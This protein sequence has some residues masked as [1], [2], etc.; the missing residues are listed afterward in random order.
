M[1]SLMDNERM[2]ESLKVHP[3]TH[4]VLLATWIIDKLLNSEYV[5][6]CVVTISDDQLINLLAEGS[7]TT[8]ATMRILTLNK[9]DVT[10]ISYRKPDGRI[11]GH[12]YIINLLQRCDKP[13]H[14]SIL[15]SKAKLA[16][17]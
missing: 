16:K 11:S 12:K 6:D 9:F 14:Y 8:G 4:H 2:I 3:L 13:K 17:V 7:L 10:N 1:S 5:S 15:A